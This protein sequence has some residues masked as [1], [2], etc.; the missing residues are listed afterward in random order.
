[1]NITTSITGDCRFM[2]IGVTGATNN[3]PLIVNVSNGA[4]E[5]N[6]STVSTSTGTYTTAILLSSTVGTQSGIFSIEVIDGSTSVYSAE[7]CK[8]ELG[9]CIAKKVDSLL[10]CDCEC[11]KC[12]DTMI[13]AE[14]VHLLI[15]AI[16]TDLAQIGEDEAANS[17]I[18]TNANAKYNKALELC[19]DSCGCNC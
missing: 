19:S 16:E 8:C 14:R 10:S 18:I 6:I 13:T 1:M 12:S 15:V 7:L 5:H 17:A 9:C 4:N 11:T 2:S 3:S